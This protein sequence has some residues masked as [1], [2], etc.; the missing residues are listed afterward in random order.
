MENNESAQVPAI[1]QEPVKKKNRGKLG[2]NKLESVSLS[3]ENLQKLNTILGMIP[4]QKQVN[5]A[6]KLFVYLMDAFFEA[7]TMQVMFDK[8]QENNNLLNSQLKEKDEL[9]EKKQELT[10]IQAP[11]KVSVQPTLV[12]KPKPNNL[13]FPH[14]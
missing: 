6:T 14:L 1:D 8:L 5:N 10:P 3:M 9:L 2:E 7:H 12:T 11:T 13:L 4:E